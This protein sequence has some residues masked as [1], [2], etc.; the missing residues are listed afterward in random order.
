MRVN[1]FNDELTEEKLRDLLAKAN[2]EAFD[3]IRK[4][5]PLFKSLNI[6]ED[7]PSDEIIKLLVKNP[8]LL[9]RPIVEFGKKAVLARPIEKVKELLNL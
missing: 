4:K 7:T 2:L 5:E 1:Y 3:V 8:N 9:Q 6:S